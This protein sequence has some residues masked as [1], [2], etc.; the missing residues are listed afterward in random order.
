MRIAGCLLVILCI[1]AGCST[2]YQTATPEEF[3][4][5]A[6]LGRRTITLVD[7]T[8]IEAKLV[9]GVSD[10]VVFH[11]NGSNMRSSLPIS[12]IQ[13]ITTTDH[14][15]GTAD[16]LLLGTVVG[17]GMGL[18]IGGVLTLA[19]RGEE[20]NG[21]ALVVFPP[22]FGGIGIITGLIVGSLSGH[23]FTVLPPRDSVMTKGGKG[24]P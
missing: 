11:L 3:A 14:L 2:T 6:G 8:Q 10:S 15:R 21:L 18:V 23:D 17:G 12:R 19:H 20:M 9:K 5:K 1:A 22:V 7:S 4:K 24:T 16:G 13:S